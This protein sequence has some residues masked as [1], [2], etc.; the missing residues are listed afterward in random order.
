[1]PD[2]RDKLVTFREEGDGEPLFFLHGVGGGVMFVRELVK[3]LKTPRPV[4][5][6]QAPPLDGGA[7]L[8]R[9][10]ADIAADYLGVVRQRQPKG[11]Y[12]FAGYC[13]G[14]WIAYEMA[15]QLIA[16]GERV[17]FLGMI[18]PSIPNVKIASQVQYHL[19][20]MKQGSQASLYS[21]LAP[22]IR[23]TAQYHFRTTV[24]RISAMPND[25]RHALGVPIPYLQRLAFYK[26][27]FQGASGS[28]SPKPYHGQIVLFGRSNTLGAHYARWQTLAK[29]GVVVRE[30]P[31]G[32]RELV[33]PPFSSLLAQHIDSFLEAPAAAEKV[34]ESA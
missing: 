20:Q 29:N 34:L 7:K 15:Q 31:A 30:I 33:W 3:D 10:M 24:K 19:K 12:A 28:Y 1:M 11:P 8:P 18:D 17:A 25:L 21:Y 22:K 26:H 9:T 2:G 32:H 16:A 4:F 23:K 14:G 27:V 5:G 13:L 6:I